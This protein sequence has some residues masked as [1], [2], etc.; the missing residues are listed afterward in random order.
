LFAQIPSFPSKKALIGNVGF[1]GK[2][3]TDEF[4]WPEQLM[5]NDLIKVVWPMLDTAR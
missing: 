4:K 3:W 2:D 5:I 1:S